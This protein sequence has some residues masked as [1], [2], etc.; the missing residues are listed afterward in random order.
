MQLELV[1]GELLEAFHTVMVGKITVNLISFNKLHD[2][3]KNVSLRLPEGYELLMGLHFNCM[4]W[5]YENVQAALLADHNFMLATF[6]PSNYCK[7]AT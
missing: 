7:Q 2:I 5:Y 3:L 6:F 1:V 4:P